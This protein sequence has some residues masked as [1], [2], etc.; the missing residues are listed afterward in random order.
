MEKVKKYG[1]LFS[2]VIF[3]RIAITCV[4]E[5]IYVLGDYGLKLDFLPEFVL[6]FLDVYFY[7]EALPFMFLIILAMLIVWLILLLLF[8]RKEISIATIILS[9]TAPIITIIGWTAPFWL[10]EIMEDETICVIITVV[11]SLIHTVA[12]GV[13]LIKDKEE[14]DYI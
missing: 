1:Y 11:L 12:T 14:F 6:H 2:I 8:Y 9:S 13:F 5:Y 4:L 7:Y 10:R 3:I